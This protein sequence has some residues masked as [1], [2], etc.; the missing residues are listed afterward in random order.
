VICGA[1]L[2]G[3]AGPIKAARP[4]RGEPLAGAVGPP[5]LGSVVGHGYHRP[6]HIGKD[7]R[8]EAL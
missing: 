2:S 5:I 3:F 8:L 7:V 6:G 4:D 1:K